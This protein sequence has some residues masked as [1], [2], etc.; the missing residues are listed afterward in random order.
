MPWVRRGALI[1]AAL[2]LAAVVAVYGVAVSSLPRTTGTLALPGLHD[3]VEVARDG[4]GVPVITA[5]SAHDAYLVLGFVHAQD[6]LFQMEFLRRLGSGRLAE[7]VGQTGLPNDRFMRT[8][9]L[10]QAAESSLA[11]VDAET[12]QA[13][14]AYAAG[15]NAFLETREGLLPP[16]LLLLGLEPEP[17]TPV[18]SL[19]WQRL[20][21]LRLSGNWHE[22]ALRAALLDVLPPDRVAELWPAEDGD[23]PTTLGAL[24]GPAFAAL[25][26]AWPAALAPTLA[27]NAWAVD[28]TRSASG[29][30]LLANDPHLG[31]AV[32]NV[33]YLA[34]LR[35][36]EWTVSGATVP[37]VPFHVLGHNGRLAW[38]FTTTHSDTMDLFVEEPAGPNTYR[39]PDG[40]LPFTE[41][42]EIIAVRDAP[43][44]TLVVRAT[45]HGPVVSDLLAVSLPE[46]SVLA[47]SAAALAPRDRT[48]EALRRL[49]RAGSWDEAV[50]AL[51]VYHAPQQ[52]VFVA[53]GAGTIGFIAPG[54]VPVR[55]NG[56]GLVPRPGAEGAYDWKGWLPVAT[57]PRGASPSGGRL[58]NA[59]NK[60]VPDSYP[61]L[62]AVHWPD[63]FRAARIEEVLAGL[64]TATPEAMRRLQL[65]SRSGVFHA[66]WPLMADTRP[67]TPAAAEAL[68]ALAAWDGTMDV[69][70]PEPLVFTAWRL[71][72]ERAIFADDLGALYPRWEGSHPRLLAR[73]LGGGTKGAWC[74]DVTTPGPETCADQLEASL[75]ATLDS[76]GAEFGPP[77]QWR[78]GAAHAVRLEHP[79]L[80]RIPGLGAIAT[81]TAELDGSDETVNR[82]GF[83]GRGES[84][85]Q[86]LGRVHGAGLR[87][88][89]DLANL[90]DS[91]FV[92]AG[93][94]SGHPLSR[95][96]RDFMTPWAAGDLM[97]IAPGPE[98]AVLTLAPLRST[99]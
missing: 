15:V 6:R 13:L 14:T 73:V 48:A 16:D 21:A 40:P 90:E 18:D 27:S 9:G 32:P 63:P 33:W 62:L 43:A 1:I 84:W 50:T 39:A 36:P 17:W 96:Y 99:R 69:D 29:A 44:E 34:E 47:L 58:V 67:A 45:R 89:Y 53:D 94:Q 70:R 93:G 87:A 66:L 59:N 28:G 8:L 82:G 10:R 42:L 86:R 2:L 81:L 61:H 26:E 83:S 56:R 12:R 88:V 60:P 38:G 98:A 95:H 54:R 30:P 71:T 46:G 65:D 3:T 80:G 72:L 52:N 74:D 79:V 51:E 7:A 68:V 19:L 57:L 23:A 77:E 37:G 76:L 55:R 49:N 91:G 41:R 22:E 20:M 75:T 64:E 5:G 31:L 4:R 97:P 78:W 11:A 25:L 35:T 92:I 85:R 24:P